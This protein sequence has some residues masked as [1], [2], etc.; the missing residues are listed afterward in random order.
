[1]GTF[2]RFHRGPD[3]A[4]TPLFT[5]PEPLGPRNGPSGLPGPCWSVRQGTLGLFRGCPGARNVGP[6]PTKTVLFILPEPLGPQNGHLGLPLEPLLECPAGPFGPVSALPR[7]S[8]WPLKA[9]SAATWPSKLPLRPAQVLVERPA[10][11]LGLFWRCQ[12]AQNGRSK[13][14]VC[15]KRRFRLLKHCYT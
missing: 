3:Q 12:G 9:S 5:A 15:L 11:R 7:R 8:K 14:P 4:K 13:P 1:M 10:G 2:R 6:R